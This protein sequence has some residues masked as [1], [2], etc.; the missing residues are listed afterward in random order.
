MASSREGQQKEEE[1]GEAIDVK[2]RDSERSGE[3]SYGQR[4]GRAADEGEGSYYSKKGKREMLERGAGERERE[5]SMLR[6]GRTGCVGVSCRINR[7][8]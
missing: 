6:K 5:G 2:K 8:G 4:L 1:K 3:S 7:K